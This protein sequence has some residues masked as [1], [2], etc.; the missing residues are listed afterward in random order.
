V[1]PEAEV[2]L[3]ILAANGGEMMPVDAHREFD[4]VMMLSP[5]ARDEWRRRVQPLAQAHA[6]RRLRGNRDEAEL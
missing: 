4:R 2:L 3:L 1:T 5:E 6:R